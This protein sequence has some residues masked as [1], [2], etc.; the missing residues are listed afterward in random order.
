M[1]REVDILE[2]SDGK[3]YGINDVV[4]IACNDCEGCSKCCK[5]MDKLI[6]LDPYDVHMLL[7]G[8]KDSTFDNILNNKIEFM[9]DKGVIIPAL[10]M[11]D[12]TGNC[13]FLNSDGRCSIHGFRPGICRLF[14]MGRLY[15][16][17]TFSYFLQKDECDYKIKTKVK[18]KKWL[19]IKEI[20]RYE[21]F[22]TDWHYFLK[23]IQAYIQSRIDESS[24]VESKK[25]SEEEIS[26]INSVI[27]KIFYMTPYELDF[28]NDFYLRLN[29][30]KDLME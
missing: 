21:K 3:K 19:D 7:S 26:Q 6:T 17:G 5:N 16:N 23:D 4:K 2:I 8:L 24:D 30:V 25:N 22:I 28:Y 14:P 20:S 9:V 29:K 1:E 18:L 11:N 15:E 27:I 13:I 12:N 10:K